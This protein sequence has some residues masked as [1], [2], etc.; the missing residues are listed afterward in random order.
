MT[1]LQLHNPAAIA[2]ITDAIFDILRT[3][4]RV[5]I[6]QD[7]P[8]HNRAK[9][10]AFEW[11]RWRVCAWREHVAAAA[12]ALSS[13][14]ALSRKLED[15]VVSREVAVD[16][17]EAHEMLV[18]TLREARAHG[19]LGERGKPRSLLIFALVDFDGA[20]RARILAERAAKHSSTLQLLNFPL[21][22]KYAV[23]VPLFLPVLVHLASTLVPLIAATIGV[24]RSYVRPHDGEVV[25]FPHLK[26]AHIKTD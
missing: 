14:H 6:E 7:A 16:V 8:K 19:R 25:F 1:A 9:T 12:H 23:Y 26:S 4:L 17:Y 21:E 24:F 10:G 20:L 5:P 13:I 2:R 18:A 22:Q 3:Q 15:L 11:R